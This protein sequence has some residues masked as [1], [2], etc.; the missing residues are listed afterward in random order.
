[1]EPQWSH[2]GV[3]TR[4]P[5]PPPMQHPTRRTGMATIGRKATQQ[6]AMRKSEQQHAGGHVMQQMSDS[7]ASPMESWIMEKNCV[8]GAKKV[9]MPIQMMMNATKRKI[10]V[11]VA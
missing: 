9:T 3:L 4:K 2:N 10:H 7:S 11:M 5:P 6:S 8:A 1:M